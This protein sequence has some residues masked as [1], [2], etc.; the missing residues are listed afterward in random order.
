MSSGQEVSTWGLRPSPLAR[1]RAGLQASAARRRKVE[2]DDA[3]VGQRLGQRSDDGREGLLHDERLHRG[4]AEDVDLLRHGEA[5]V[6]RHQQRAEPRAGIEQ[7]EIVRV[8]GG[9]DGD[10][11][12]AAHAQLRFERTGRVGNAL[13]QLRIGQRA[14][15]EA[16]RGLVGRKCGVAV[17]EV[18]EVHGAELSAVRASGV[19]DHGTR[20][21]HRVDRQLLV[22]LPA[23]RGSRGRCGRGRSRRSRAAS[24][25]RSGC[26]D[27]CARALRFLSMAWPPQV[28]MALAASALA[29]SITVNCAA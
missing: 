23:R 28:R 11:V 18:G 14:P 12:A 13:R 15:R 26:R 4:I 3:H 2:A 5:P 24:A 22:R 6:E 9:E 8:V 7:H 21:V 1:L 20:R 10:A 17:D 27:R 25:S 16:D 29:F 19:W